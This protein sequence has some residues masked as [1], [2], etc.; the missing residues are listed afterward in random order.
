MLI[1]DKKILF[2]GIYRKLHQLYI[3][4]N[5]VVTD[6]YFELIHDN[7]DSYET[8]FTRLK[9]LLCSDLI[10]VEIET[11]L[12][13]KDYFDNIFFQNPEIVNL[14]RKHRLINYHDLNEYY[15]NR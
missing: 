6:G 2:K 5:H 4:R 15:N 3:K 8:N 9:R 12:K 13:G 1:P 7:G 10:N 11:H 14:L